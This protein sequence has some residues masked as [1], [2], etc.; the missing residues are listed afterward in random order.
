MVLRTHLHYD[1]R[2]WQLTAED[3]FF[4]GEGTAVQAEEGR[5][6]AV[7]FEHNG[8]AFVRKHYRR[9][10]WVRRIIRDRYVY[11]GLERTRMWR[12]YR[13]LE[14]MTKLGLPVPEPVAVRCVCHG[15]FHYSGDLVTV[16]LA[17]M[18]TLESLLKRG[19][20]SAERWAEVGA[21][22]ARFHRHS[23]YHAD[24]NV[25]NIMLG[26]GDAVALID[27]DKGGI[28]PVGSGVW[29]NQNMQ[30]LLRSLRKGLL[31]HGRFHFTEADWETLTR[32]HA[33]S[34]GAS[35]VLAEGLS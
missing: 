9:G 34:M 3:L 27:F 5:G 23:V 7:F 25:A 17:G 4:D 22:L 24:L 8:Q 29:I 33:E 20:L 15:P 2:K 10:G 28:R 30:R 21:T 14:R 12:E 26:E 32:R 18:E 35:E 13:L 31:R 11:C 6:A 16:R 1:S 19:P